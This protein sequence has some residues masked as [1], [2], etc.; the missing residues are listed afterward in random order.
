MV[1]PPIAVPDVDDWAP[2]PATI[3]V[4]AI[5]HENVAEP[6]KPAPSV[7]VIVTD[8]VPAVVGVPVIDPVELLIDSPAGSPVALQVSVAP[9]WLSVADEARV[10]MAVPDVP[11]WVPG[12]S[13]VTWLVTVHVKV[14]V[15]DWLDGSVAVRVTEQVQGAVGVPEMVPF[16]VLMVRPVGRPVADQVK[17]DTPD[18]ESVAVLVRAV[19]AEPVTFVRL[20]GFVTATVLVTVQEIVVVPKKPAPSVALSVTE[21]V[22]GVVGVPVI[23]PVDELI[24]SPVGRPAADHVRVAPDWVSVAELV[25]AVMA[26]PVTA[27]LLPGLATVTVLVTVQ[28]K[29]VVPDWFDGSVAVR[30]TEDVPGVVGVPVIDPDELLMDSPLGRPVA[31]QVSVAPDCES[32]A[33]LARTV[34]GE[35]VTL[36][37]LPGLV[38]ATV[39]V[40]VQ[41]IAVVPK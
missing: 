24:D 2:W 32:V 26:V 33:V 30:V 23:D 5:V 20:P 34:M 31:D 11:V 7:A 9:D 41:V 12:L 18:C 21:Q 25:T 39:L 15:P 36:V 22:Q 13:T 29:V 37:W 17:D 3:T 19:M 1:R 28:V 35:P 10:A 38:T 16:E 8:E 4:L 6:E 40:T 27:D 14:A